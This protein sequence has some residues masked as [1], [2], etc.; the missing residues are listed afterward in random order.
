MQ[1]MQKKK[2]KKQLL[3]HLM[4]ATRIMSANEHNQKHLNHLHVYVHVA[5]SVDMCVRIN[6]VVS[7]LKVHRAL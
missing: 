5:A 6:S 7:A 3:L 2:T 4:T 1:K